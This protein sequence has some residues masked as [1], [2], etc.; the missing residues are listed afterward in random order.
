MILSF[1]FRITD[2]EPN[3]Y[4]EGESTSSLSELKMTPSSGSFMIDLMGI[5]L[6]IENNLSIV[7]KRISI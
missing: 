6:E 2:R 7:S 4:I 3:R 5:V 1:L